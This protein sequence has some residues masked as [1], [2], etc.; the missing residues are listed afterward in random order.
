MSFSAA[1]LAVTA[2]GKW[3]GRGG[4]GRGGREGVKG[5]TEYGRQWNPRDA[6]SSWSMKR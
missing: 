5:E 2:E 6:G 4:E 3:R 1:R